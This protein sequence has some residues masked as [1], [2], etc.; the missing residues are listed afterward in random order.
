MAGVTNRGKLREREIVLTNTVPAAL[1]AWKI[2][3]CTSASL[4]TADTNTLSELTQVANAF[5]YLQAGYNVPRSTAGWDSITED[6]TNDRARALL[7]D[8]LVAASG[9][10]IA[11]IKSIVVAD[12]NATLGSREIYYYWIL[13]TA[14]TLLDGDSVNLKDFILDTEEAA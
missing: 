6:D 11:D 5:G 10:S 12:A 7:V 1:T 2:H 8:T 9:G 3:L 13:A 4:P 14:L